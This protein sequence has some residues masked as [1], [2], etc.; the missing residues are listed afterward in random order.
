MKK[1]KK[2]GRNKSI[3]E[4]HTAKEI[5]G[6]ETWVDRYECVQIIFNTF[7]YFLRHDAKIVIQIK[8]YR[9]RFNSGCKFAYERT[10]YWVRKRKRKKKAKWKK[11]WKR[12]K[13]FFFLYFNAKECSVS[14]GCRFI[15]FLFSNFFFHLL[16]GPCEP[17]SKDRI[18]E[19]ESSVV[20]K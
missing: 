14:A 9:S 10:I 5:H 19:C 12:N 13:N 4:N 3:K 11:H 18:W 20:A 7:F 16:P 6:I 17:K 2:W 15:A 1:K 8:I